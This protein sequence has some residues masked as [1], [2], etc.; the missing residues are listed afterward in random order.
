M[1]DTKDGPELH[2]VTRELAGGPNYAAI[3]TLLPS[4]RIQTQ[5]I[6]VG[7]DGDRLFVNTEA[8]RRKFQDMQ[9]D[10]RVTLAIRD[11]QNPYHYAEV[12]GRVVG[13]EGGQRARDQIDE[14][15]QKYDGR[16]YPPESIKTER[17]TVYIEPERQTIMG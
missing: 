9:R 6:W 14:L 13:T 7:V 10:G 15:S 17:V 3:S 1:A 8:H 5:Y 2:P 12:R 4:G 16:P 11:E